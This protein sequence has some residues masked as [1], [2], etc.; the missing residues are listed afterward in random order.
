M[1]INEVKEVKDFFATRQRFDL[2]L[3]CI[4][5]LLYFRNLV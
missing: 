3:L 1:E 2:C 5:Y 4:L